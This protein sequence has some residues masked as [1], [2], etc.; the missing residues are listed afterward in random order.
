MNFVNMSSEWDV[1]L[2]WVGEDAA[3]VSRSVLEKSENHIELMSSDHVWCLVARRHTTED[4]DSDKTATDDDV[5]VSG[6]SSVS[7]LFRPPQKGIENVCKRCIRVMWI[8]WISLS[9]AETT[10]QLSR[11]DCNAYPDIDFKIFDHN[12]TSC[13]FSNKRN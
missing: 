5:E 6:S 2:F 10:T 12:S 3:L 11:D 7:I 1:E 9:F 13:D 4:F 8:P